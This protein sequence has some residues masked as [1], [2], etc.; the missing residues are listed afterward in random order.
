MQ[1]AV[2]SNPMLKAMAQS[3]PEIKSHDVKSSN[4]AANAPKYK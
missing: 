4:I 3:N 1:Q 2:N